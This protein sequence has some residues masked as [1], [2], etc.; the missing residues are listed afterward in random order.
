MSFCLKLYNTVHICFTIHRQILHEIIVIQKKNFFFSLKLDFIKKKKLRKLSS[1]HI[2]QTNVILLP[3][4]TN[5]YYP[6]YMLHT[7]VLSF[8]HITQTSIIILPFY[9]N[10]YYPPYM[11][12]KNIILLPYYTNQYYPPSILHK[13]VLS[14]FRTT[15]IIIIRLPY[16][17]NKYYLPSVLHK[18]V[19]QYIPLKYGLVYFTSLVYSSTN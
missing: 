1:L 15:Q 8:F 2:A 4:Y 10:K 11:Y 14:S 13:P 17:T 12:T 18:Q 7:Q 9:T 19:L 3:H 16:Y 6:P 5:K